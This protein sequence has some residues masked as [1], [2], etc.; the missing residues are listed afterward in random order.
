MLEFTE[1]P[2]ATPSGTGLFDIGISPSGAYFAPAYLTSAAWVP[3]YHD[4]DSWEL[5][6]ATGWVAG[7]S[8]GIGFTPDDQYIYQFVGGATLVRGTRSG[9]DFVKDGWEIAVG[10]GCR[11]LAVNPDNTL[12]AVAGGTSVVVYDVA[13]KAQVFIYNMG[14]TAEEVAFSP[15]GLSL[16]AT[17]RG[18]GVFFFNVSGLTVT[19]KRSFAVGNGNWYISWHNDSDH[20]AFSQYTVGS[21]FHIYKRVAD[22]YSRLTFTPADGGIAQQI[23]MLSYLGGEYKDYIIAG[24]YSPANTKIY[25]REG[26]AYTL[27]TDHD[28]P[29]LA[30]VEGLRSARTTGRLVLFHTAS[31]QMRAWDYSEPA[32]PANDATIELTGYL[33]E[34]AAEI[35]IPDSLTAELVG[36]LGEISAT[37]EE[38]QPIAVTVELVGFLPTTAATIEFETLD[39]EAELTGYL[40]ETAAEVDFAPHI[41][42]TSTMSGY[43]PT[44]SAEVWFYLSVGGETIGYLGELSASLE[45]GLPPDPITAESV[46]SGYLP[47]IAAELFTGNPPVS[48]YDY[49]DDLAFAV[50]VI[51]EFG[52]PYTLTRLDKGVDPDNPLGPSLVANATTNAFGVNIEVIGNEFGRY[53]NLKDLL[54]KHD[55]VVLFPGHTSIDYS[56]YHLLTDLDTKVW[57]IGEV[58]TFKPGNLAILHFVGI[59]A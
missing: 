10:A 16:A 14:G 43:P 41:S 30:G 55:G 50:E 8:T 44:T 39:V 31:G 12:I 37:I 15:D 5:G 53:I 28:F 17:S 20:V 48:T 32:V 54:A 19:F 40:G 24:G 3:R 23:L 13:T 59:T 7:T 25:K 35:N 47:T 1:L 26:D 46:M 18:T 11:G 34:T 27:F 21:N 22:D 52:S 49:S 56:S 2:V 38:V 33:G 45:V 51:T 36:Y 4:G 57:K 6:A 58:M 29:S 42:V 9:N